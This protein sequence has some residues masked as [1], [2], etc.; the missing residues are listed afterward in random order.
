MIQ[1]GHNVSDAKLKAMM[2]PFGVIRNSYLAEVK[3][4]DTILS[5][6]DK[7]LVV[8]SITTIPITAPITDALSYMIYGVDIKTA[9]SVM[10]RN[11]GR[12]IQNE[13]LY[14]IIY[15]TIDEA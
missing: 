11:H 12:N 1:V 2:L 7:T 8:K 13:Y 14:I 3:A 6:D 4:G 10:R 9:F 5:M 15:D